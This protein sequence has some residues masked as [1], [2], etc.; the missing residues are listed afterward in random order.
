VRNDLDNP[1]FSLFICHFKFRLKGDT[2]LPSKETLHCY[3]SED[4][5][6]FKE[7]EMPRPW[8]KEDEE[9]N[10]YLLEKNGFLSENS[11]IEDCK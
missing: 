9:F 2:M 1:D 4:D 11:A 8:T 7:E 5:A 3:I 6:P 10:T